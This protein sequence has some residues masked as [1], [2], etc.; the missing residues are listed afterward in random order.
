MKNNFKSGGYQKLYTSKKESNPLTDRKD[1]KNQ[2]GS[3]VAKNSS[4][5]KKNVGN[6]LDIKSKNEK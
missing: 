4:A 6:S 5:T 1:Y 2:K 3:K